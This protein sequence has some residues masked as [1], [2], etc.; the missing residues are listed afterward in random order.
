LKSKSYNGT[1]KRQSTVNYPTFDHTVERICNN[2]LITTNHSKS[3]DKLTTHGIHKDNVRININSEIAGKNRYLAK[4][5]IHAGS[6]DENYD[7]TNMLY[8]ERGRLG[9]GRMAVNILILDSRT[10]QRH[11]RHETFNHNFDHAM[12]DLQHTDV[13]H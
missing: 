1:H 13:I 4:K 11:T 2:G 5:A 3:K 8:D 7:K 9:L 6:F 12:A 10:E